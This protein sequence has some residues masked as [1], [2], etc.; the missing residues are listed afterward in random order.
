MYIMQT[1]IDCSEGICE[2]TG[3]KQGK[4]PF[5][6]LG[7]LIA[8]RKLNAGDCEMLVDKLSARIHSW[9]SRNLSY[10]GRVQL[11]NSVLINIHSY[12]AVI[13]ILPKKV[14]RD[15]IAICRNYL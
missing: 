9:G 14:L 7:V 3:Y 10:A 6:Y 13:F 8:A 5:K 11:I 12:W 15:I 1:W 2:I 4:L